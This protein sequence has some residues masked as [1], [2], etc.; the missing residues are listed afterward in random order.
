MEKV[1][2]TLSAARVNM[3]SVKLG[4]ALKSDPSRPHCLSIHRLFSQD[5]LFFSSFL[6]HNKCKVV[7]LSFLPFSVVADAE[8]FLG[9][10]PA[11]NTAMLVVAHLLTCSRSLSQPVAALLREM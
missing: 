4:T 2:E 10:M 7:L 5:K 1:D 6:K 9:K 8:F 3:H 11:N